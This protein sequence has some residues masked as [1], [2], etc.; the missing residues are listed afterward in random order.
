MGRRR[1]SELS[2]SPGIDIA[3]TEALWSLDLARSY[4]RKYL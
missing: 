4:S 3:G 1:S 2:P